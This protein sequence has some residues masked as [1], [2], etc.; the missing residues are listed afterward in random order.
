MRAGD[1]SLAQQLVDVVVRLLV[2]PWNVIAFLDESGVRVAAG[3]NG[4]RSIFRIRQLRQIA[5]N[6]VNAQDDLVGRLK[7]N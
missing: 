3:H 2:G 1:W 4:R 5:R 7:L 6:S